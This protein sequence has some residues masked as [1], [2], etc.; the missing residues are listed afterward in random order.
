MQNSNFEQL[1]QII[2][3]SRETYLKLE[4]FAA[5][6]KEKNLNLNLI[7][8]STANNIWER[9]IIDS[10]QLAK[11]LHQDTKIIDFGSGAGLP[12]MIL[13]LCGY[14][15]T[16]VES[17]AKK[18]AFQKEAALL[19][20]LD[21]NILNERI[22]NIRMQDNYV[23]TARAVAPLTKLFKLSYHLLKNGNKAL[24]MKGKNYQNEI[25]AA[26]KFWHFNYKSYKSITASDSVIL[27]ISGLKWK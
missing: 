11:Y 7:G 6:L 27:E 22:E 21:I 8:S 10:I 4:K 5:L 19:L 14:A 1:K 15:V 3:V 9:H 2:N 23:L 18:S 12:G 26:E 20:N 25:L 13:A 24:F 17:I 16:S